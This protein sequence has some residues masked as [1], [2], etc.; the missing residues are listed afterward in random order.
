MGYSP[1]GHKE[2]VMTDYHLTFITY[3]W[4]LKYN[5]NELI[6]EQRQTDIEKRLVIT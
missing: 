2:S 6:Y 4:N 3:I 1:G 5:T